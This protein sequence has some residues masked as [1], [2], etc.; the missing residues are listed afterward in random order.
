[1]NQRLNVSGRKSRAIRVKINPA[2]DFREVIHAFDAIEIPPTATGADN[3]RFTILEL[4][5]NS[6]RA[7]K[8]RGESRDILVDLTMTDG[9]L[10]IAI[11]DYGGGFD[12]KLLPY[13]LNADPATLDIHGETF[14]EYQKKNA[15]KRF[16]MG[17][18]LAK[19]TFEHFQLLFL[20]EKEM[21]VIWEM[22]RIFGTLIRV[23]IATRE[24]A[25]GLANG[26]VGR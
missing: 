11:R 7:H 17:I 16:G 10:H 21:P 1:M 3:L 25:G 2:A 26:H 12:P 8:E 5:N 13:P 24:D 14:Q 6:I 23:D 20:D 19:K 9:R 18:Y 15:Y 22:G 4:V